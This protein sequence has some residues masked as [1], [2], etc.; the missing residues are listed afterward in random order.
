[1]QSKEHY[2]SRITFP[3]AQDILTFIAALALGIRI[4]NQRVDG[5]QWHSALMV[6]VSETPPIIHDRAHVYLTLALNG[7]SCFTGERS[8]QMSVVSI[9]VPRTAF[10]E[11]EKPSLS[12]V[13]LNPRP[14]SEEQFS[15][16]I[17]TFR[18]YP[19][20]P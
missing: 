9:I 12:G 8:V 15:W 19:S 11:H 1:M 4:M 20:Y 17:L 5:N 16:A 2:P 10:E 7:R 6:L 14:R 18:V 13:S 3:S